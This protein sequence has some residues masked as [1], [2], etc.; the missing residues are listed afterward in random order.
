[1]AGFI[2]MVRCV[3][4]VIIGEKKTRKAK[5]EKR[6]SAFTQILPAGINALSVYRGISKKVVHQAPLWLRTF[7]GL[8]RGKHSDRNGYSDRGY[9]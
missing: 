5:K 6:D 2:W 4:M 8:G 3:K 7:G 9:Y 1:M